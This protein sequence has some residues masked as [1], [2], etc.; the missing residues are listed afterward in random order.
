MRRLTDAVD[1]ALFLVG[2]AGIVWI[3]WNLV[4]EIIR[5]IKVR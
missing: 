3:G 4:A 1:T 5:C 2:G